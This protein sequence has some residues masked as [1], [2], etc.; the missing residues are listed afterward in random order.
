MSRGPWIGLA[1]AHP[2][3]NTALHTALQDTRDV[4]LGMSAGAQDASGI[5]DNT[6]SDAAL[7]AQALSLIHISEPTR[8]Y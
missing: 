2:I 1:R 3:L 5:S 6:N 4:G 7:A 8:P